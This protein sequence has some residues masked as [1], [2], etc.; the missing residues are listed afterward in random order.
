MLCLI[1]G[2]R[3]S[4]TTV[5]RL[6][7]KCGINLTDKYLQT[8]KEP[9]LIGITLSK[10][11]GAIMSVS[12]WQR[13]VS[14]PLKAIPRVSVNNDGRITVGVQSGLIFT[15]VFY[16]SKIVI[17]DSDNNYIKNKHLFR[18][19]GK[20]QGRHY[21]WNLHISLGPLD[22]REYEVSGVIFG[23]WQYD[24]TTVQ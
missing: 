23:R 20:A 1:V 17:L 18:I 9:S 2:A 12:R 7:S 5:T 16:I 15:H 19:C 11:F 21:S 13:H 24:V 4:R 6:A 8:F 3:C 22:Q 10:F 14:F